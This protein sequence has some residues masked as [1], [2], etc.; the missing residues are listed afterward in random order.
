MPGALFSQKE[1]EKRNFLYIVKITIIIVICSKNDMIDSINS[2]ILHIL[3]TD[4]RRSYSEIG[5]IVGLSITAV[6]ERIVKLSERG[7]L[8]GYSALV[9]PKV[10]GF[11]ILAFVFVSIDKSEQCRQFEQT[12]KKCADIQECHHVTGVFNYLL[13]VRA[14]SVE[15]LERVLEEEIKRPGITARTETTLVLSSAKET[16]Y[17][18]CQPD[19]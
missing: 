13:K 11:G 4:S 9:N 10:A 8:S 3:Q 2:K 14:R 19:K 18:D 15:D 12:V 6:K 5:N 1:V 17:L 7:V 16:A